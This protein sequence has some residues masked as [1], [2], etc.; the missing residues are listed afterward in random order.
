MLSVLSFIPLS[1]SAA[2]SSTEDD[3]CAQMLLGLARSEGVLIHEK[4]EKAKEDLMSLLAAETEEDEKR[5]RFD[6]FAGKSMLP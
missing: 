4:E 5:A 1:G 2:A 3:L 6:W